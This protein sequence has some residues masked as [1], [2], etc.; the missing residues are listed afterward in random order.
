MKN[1]LEG[2]NRRSDDAE[3]W[4]NK[5]EDMAMESNKA[6]QQKGKKVL[7]EELRDLYD[8]FKCNNIH[9]IGVPEGE[10]RKK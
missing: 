8:N 10:E 6:E 4:I 9:I 5:L 7:N 3:E 2:I 1:I